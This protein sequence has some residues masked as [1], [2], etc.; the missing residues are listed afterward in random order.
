M[1]KLNYVGIKQAKHERNV[2]KCAVGKFILNMVE[3]IKI[4]MRS[5]VMPKLVAVQPSPWMETI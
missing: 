4:L 3:E 5:N 2:R 1:S